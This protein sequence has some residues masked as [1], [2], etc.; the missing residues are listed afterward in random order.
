[1]KLIK[2]LNHLKLE[3]K[4]VK[5]E[6]DTRGMFIGVSSTMNWACVIFSHFD[7]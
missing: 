2:F 5:I 3:K 6:D 4:Y 7:I 1:M